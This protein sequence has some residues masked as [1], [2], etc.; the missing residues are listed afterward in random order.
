MMDIILQ[1]DW[2]M[3]VAD[4]TARLKIDLQNSTDRNMRVNALRNSDIRLQ[5]S[6]P[7]YATRAGH[8]LSL[9]HI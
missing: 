8:N 6:D 3:D 9:I 7:D 5:T 1:S 4:I 2:I